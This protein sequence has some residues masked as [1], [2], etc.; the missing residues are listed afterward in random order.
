M[1][2][3][4][5]TWTRSLLGIPGGNHGLAAQAAKILIPMRRS[6][7]ASGGLAAPPG[8]AVEPCAETCADEK[9]KDKARPGKTERHKS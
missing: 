7:S 4:T 3:T 1:A 8:G 5:R 9:K 6:R 2:R